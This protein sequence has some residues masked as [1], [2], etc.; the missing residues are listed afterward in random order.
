M[1][2]KNLFLLGS[3]LAGAAY[4]QNKGRR[5]RLVGQARG[6]I[7]RAKTRASELVSSVQHKTDN[8]GSDV[9]SFADNGI[10]SSV[11]STSRYGD[12]GIGGSGTYR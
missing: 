12:T 3:V 11:G 1:T 5:D 2:I 9:S 7:D 6:A 4:L 10:G 8:V